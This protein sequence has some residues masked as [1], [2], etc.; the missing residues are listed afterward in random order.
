MSGTFVCVCGGECFVRFRYNQV[1]AKDY[2]LILRKPGVCRYSEMGRT[3]KEDTTC[4]IGLF[5]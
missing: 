1:N 4:L 3:G 2:S 5:V